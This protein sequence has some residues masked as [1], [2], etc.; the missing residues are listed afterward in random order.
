MSSERLQELLQ[1]YRAALADDPHN[2]H[3]AVALGEVLAQLGDAGQAAR[4][5]LTAARGFAALRMTREAAQ[6]CAFV[7]TLDAGNLEAIN[8]LRGLEEGSGGDPEVRRVTQGRPV[9]LGGQDFGGVEQSAGPQDPTTEAAVPEGEY[10]EDEMTE[11]RS[12]PSSAPSKRPRLRTRRP[13]RK[14]SPLDRT[15][16][17]GG[18]ED[19]SS[20]GQP[21]PLP[22]PPP[23]RPRV[24]TRARVEGSLP[25]RRPRRKVSA[26]DRTEVEAISEQPA[27]Q[28]ATV[29][30][31]RGLATRGSGSR[32][33]AVDRTEIDRAAP[34]LGERLDYA[35]E[36]PDRTEIEV[37]LPEHQT[38]PPNDP[39][40]AQ[41]AALPAAG[42]A[43]HAAAVAEKPAS[44]AK[45]SA[46]SRLGLP[47]SYR[48]LARVLTFAAGDV[49]VQEGDAGADLF[50]VETGRLQV[51]RQTAN[52]T[53]VLAMLDDGAF[54]GEL[55]MLGDGLRH[56]TV[57]AARPTRLLA[58][59][60]AQ[61]RQLMREDRNVNRTIRRAYRDRLRETTLATAPLLEALPPELADKVL[62]GGK[63]VGCSAGEV[64]LQPGQT[65][66]GF[67]IVLLGAVEV[68]LGEQRLGEVSEG[69]CFG[70]GEL[71]AGTPS[72]YLFR[73]SRFTQLLQLLPSQFDELGREPAFAAAVENDEVEWMARI[74]QGGL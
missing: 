46:A 36:A 61:A 42:K 7:L 44:G 74:R 13:E 73:A 6:S 16:I 14:V 59:T 17:D 25:P 2:P 71:L 15:V 55:G 31:P 68:L 50:I 60:R 28:Q 69:D 52:G 27:P 41:P 51:S 37:Q 9:V 21:A 70:H 26:L 54:F 43:V 53:T 4:Y 66:S 39:V 65:A 64:L 45:T 67:F 72:R 22:P 20:P 18:A 62:A 38:A 34:A 47:E 12:A 3:L 49:V 23:A 63:P 48:Q 35:A 58:L 10:F 5:Y 8:L 30:D 32:R 19:N 40:A 56:A 57:R 1:Q 11:R 29:H 24:V 33:P